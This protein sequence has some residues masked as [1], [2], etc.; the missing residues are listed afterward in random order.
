M[1]SGMQQKMCHSDSDSFWCC[2]LYDGF[3]H[4]ST[5]WLVT[6]FI[7][8]LFINVIWLRWFDYID[9]VWNII[10]F[11]L[12]LIL[13]HQKQKTV[14]LSFDIKMQTRNSDQ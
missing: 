8:I 9:D 13:N 5:F 3:D 10:K 14:W 1:M 6:F 4:I 2:E 12:Y 11:N 7:T